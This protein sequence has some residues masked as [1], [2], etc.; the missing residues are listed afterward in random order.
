MSTGQVGTWLALIIG[1]GGGLG[2]Y[3]GG[4]VTDRMSRGDER[5]RMWVPAT[6]MALS[7]PFSFV[8]YTSSNTLL[9]LV[10]LIP[11]TLL[12]LMYQAPALAL[13]QS[14]ATP[15]MR[16]TAGAILLLVIN[17]I[18]LAMGP[19]V[20]G[21]ISDALQPRFGDDSLRYALLI[22]SMVFAWSGVHFVLAARTV[23]ED[24]EFARAATIREAQGHSI[25]S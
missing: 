23:R 7:V 19:A 5:Y 1:I 25:W 6:A 20:T 2:I 24:L 9:A 14:L 21:L 18:G 16:A 22:V 10:M 3:L 8:I 12:G 13:V 17:I 15:S 4:V 11:P